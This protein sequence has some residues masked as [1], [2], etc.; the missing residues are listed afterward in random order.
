M[1]RRKTILKPKFSLFSAGRPY[2]GI[3]FA[4]ANKRWKNTRTAAL[5]ILAP[6]MVAKFSH[7]HKKENQELIERLIKKTE[8]EGSVHPMK[9]ICMAAMNFILGTCFG[10]RNESE[11]D[12]VFKQVVE[13][14]EKGLKVAGVENDISSF[15]PILSFLDVLSR[16]GK[17]FENHIKNLRDPVMKGLV[18]GA[19]ETDQDNL[20]KRLNDLKE[21]YDLDD[22]DLLVTASKYIGLV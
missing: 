4:Q 12:P 6:N 18:K 15:L 9:P 22:D 16:R 13:M 2:R 20:L 7:Y 14:M 19:L 1:L 8:Q 11:N 17:F 3:V 10:R 5:S 21:T